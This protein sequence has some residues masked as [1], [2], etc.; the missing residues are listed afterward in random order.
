ME[1]YANNS[2][3]SGV[4]AYLIGDD[5]I[6]VQFKNSAFYKYS[7]SSAGQQAIETM[8]QLANS[9][10]GLGTYISTKATQPS[11]ESNGRSLESVL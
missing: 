6:V 9:G 7:Y 8:K 2:G 10:S 5:Y 1:P 11:H 3:R 4:V